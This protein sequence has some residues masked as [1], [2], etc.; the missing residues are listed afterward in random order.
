MVPPK[1]VEIQGSLHWVLPL[2]A[3]TFWN[4]SNPY[5]LN[6]HPTKLCFS[7]RLSWIRGA[8]GPL[9]LTCGSTSQ[10]WYRGM[11]SR[12]KMLHSG[13]YSKSE[14]PVNRTLTSRPVASLGSTV[15]ASSTFWGQERKWRVYR[16]NTLSILNLHNVICHFYLNKAGGEL[17]NDG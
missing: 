10:P 5:L 3:C 8:R 15:I 13:V 14:T 12:S 7:V 9:T 16:T 11:P 6:P 2:N 4:Q 1:M 17:E